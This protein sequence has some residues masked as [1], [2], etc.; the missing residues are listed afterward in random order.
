MYYSSLDIFE[1]IKRLVESHGLSFREMTIG[2]DPVVP[3]KLWI[4]E[5]RVEVMR[6]AKFL[7]ITDGDGRSKLFDQSLTG[8]YQ[9]SLEYIKKLLTSYKNLGSQKR[10]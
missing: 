2:K 3:I 5:P 7:R 1:E 6:T 8:W 9:N 10:Q 4:Q